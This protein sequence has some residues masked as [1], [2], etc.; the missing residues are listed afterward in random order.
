MIA[1]P[2]M[3]ALGQTAAAVDAPATAEPAQSGSSASGTVTP[4]SSPPEDWSQLP[5]L[6]LKRRQP[7]PGALSSYVRDEVRAGRCAAESPLRVDLAVLIAPA[8]QLRRI[9]PNAI[10]C[11]TV[12]QYAS[13]LVMRM[14]RGNV[15]PPLEERWYRISVTFAWQ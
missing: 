9:R 4:L 5:E 13:G 11:P 1:I 14:A 7:D 12:E 8:G 6:R 3:L 10:G 2:L 15:P